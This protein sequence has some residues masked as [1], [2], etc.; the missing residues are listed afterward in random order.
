VEI[1]HIIEERNFV[2]VVDLEELLNYVNMLGGTESV[3]SME[4]KASTESNEACN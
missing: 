2:R 3:L 1:I 4:I